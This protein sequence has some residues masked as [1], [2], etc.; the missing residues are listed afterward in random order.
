MHLAK[1]NLV[2]AFKAH[3]SVQKDVADSFDLMNKIVD[4]ITH[5]TTAEIV[6]VS[7]IALTNGEAAFRQTDAAR[8][9]PWAMLTPVE[10]FN[11][12]REEFKCLVDSEV[13]VNHH[14]LQRAF[15]LYVTHFNTWNPAPCNTWEK[16]DLFWCQI[17]GFIQRFLPAN[18]AQAFAQD[19]CYIVDRRETL[20]RAFNFRHDAAVSFFPLSDSLTGLGFNF[21]ACGVAA[22]GSAYLACVGLLVSFKTYVEQKHQAWRAYCACEITPVSHSPRLLCGNVR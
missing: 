1:D 3:D 22:R 4:A 6:H 15:D 5:A 2:E 18:L 13:M 8:A 11:R 17:I 9:T 21:A 16:C 7:G 12:L 10:K 20:R 14:Y 19:I